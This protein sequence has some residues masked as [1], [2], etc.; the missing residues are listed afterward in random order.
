MKKFYLSSAMVAMLASA[1][2]Q[3]NAKDFQFGQKKSSIEDLPVFTEDMSKAPK[4]DIQGKALTILWEDDFSGMGDLSTN[5]GTWVTAGANGAFWTTESTVHPF[6]AAGGATYT[7]NMNGRYLT[8]DSYGPVT[9]ATEPGGFSTTALFGTITTPTM[10]L[11]AGSGQIGVEFLT[12]TMYC[13]NFAERPYG[14]QFSADNGATWSAVQ[15]LSFAGKSRNENTESVATPLKVNINI[16]AIAPSLTATSKI[17]L[18]WDAQNADGNGQYNSHYYW[19]I[20]DFKVYTI[21][22]SDLT[23]TNTVYESAGLSYYNVPTAQLAPLEFSA[24]VKNNGLGALTNVQYTVNVTPG[25]ASVTSAAVP[26]LAPG[27]TDSLVTSTFTPPATVGAYTF[28]RVVSQTETDEIP[29]DNVIAPINFNVT[30]NTYSRDNGVVAGRLNNGGDPYTLGILFDAFG[31]QTIYGVDY[32]LN[33]GSTVGSEYLVKLYEFDGT[34]ATLADAIALG[35]KTQTTEEYVTAAMTGSIR[36]AK[37]QTPTVLEAGKTYYVGFENTSGG[38][39]V[40]TCQRVSTGSY[41]LDGG[42]YYNQPSVP[43]I[44]MNFDSK[45]GLGDDNNGVAISNI[46]PN[47]TTNVSTVN[48]SLNS[49]SDVTVSVTDVT[50]K[51]VFTNFVANQAVGTHSMEIN[52][53]EFNSGVYFVNVTSAGSTVTRKL[54]KK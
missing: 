18:T 6:N 45:L 21:P 12:Q 39:R 22:T 26:S 46:F 49:A 4:G 30:T 9:A 24:A 28:T 43:L 19:L 16:S 20:D 54:I 10:D 27:A 42:I 25:T 44:R 3:S 50:G 5:K 37:F 51:V 52:A 36:S 41:I 33:S 17:R 34:A 48:Y 53:K 7:Q 8:W 29:T 31:T 14:I 38:V 47:P 32:Q 1:F 23:V 15:K 11:S 40:A 13:C 35:Y 2:A